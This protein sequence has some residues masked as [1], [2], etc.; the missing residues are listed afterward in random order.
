MALRRMVTGAAVY[1]PALGRIE[2]GTN[3]NVVPGKVVFKLDRRMI[4]EEN[5]AEVEAR[6]R[7]VI[8][9]AAGRTPGIAADVRRILLAHTLKPL[10]ASQ[11]IVNALRKHAEAVFGERI[12]VCGTP[13][14][15]DARLYCEAGIPAVLGS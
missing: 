4:P 12:P 6:I 11:P 3:T 13:L 9:E 5:P 14:Y 15:T 8:A 1:S 7:A 2:G 10:P